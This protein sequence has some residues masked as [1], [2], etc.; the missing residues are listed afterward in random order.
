[1]KTSWLAAGAVTVALSL[2]M[3]SGLFFKES[4]IALID[5]ARASLMRVE[6][7]TLGVETMDREISLQGQ[8]EPAQH[9][10]LK[11]K[12]SGSLTRFLVEK[13]E[14]IT[15][16]QPLLS[17]DV[18]GRKNILT[19]ALARVKM[20]RS[21]QEAAQSLRKQRLQSQLQLEQA[22]ASL[23]SA[24]AG[25]AAVELD[26]S[27]TTITA[28][29]SGVVNDLPIDVG[30]LVERGDVVAELIDDRSFHVSAYVSQQSLSNLKVGQSVT[31]ELI[32]GENL[33]GK[34]TYISSIADMQTRSFKI[35]ARVW[36][37]SGSIAAGVSASMYIPVEQVEAT[38]ISP[39]ALSLGDNGELGVKAVNPED[40]VMFLP[41]KLV[42]T[43]LDGAWVSGIPGDTRVITMGQGF[44]NIGE[45]VDPVRAIRN[46][47]SNGRL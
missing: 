14:R 17:L 39:S 3:A 30:S 10:F 36:N 29:F 23:E 12:T 46:S 40:K 38:F 19:E 21:E 5:E 20:A 34:L 33:N 22:E 28:P 44:V 6:I 26:I 18:G 1:M 42:S 32:T 43:S 8:L 9:L 4:S 16:G 25:L 2:W 7:Q 11:A 35:E 24:L 27:N 37:T 13:G 41:I 31:V 15:L 47:P 45:I